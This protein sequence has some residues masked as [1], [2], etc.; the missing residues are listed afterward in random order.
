M[1]TLRLLALVP[2]MAISYAEEPAKNPFGDPVQPAKPDWRRSVGL[3]DIQELIGF[4]ALKYL[5]KEVAPFPEVF[6]P[7][8]LQTTG[9]G[10]PRIPFDSHDESLHV[11]E[12]Y[13]QQGNTLWRYGFD[14]TLSPPFYFLPNSTPNVV[15]RNRQLTQYRIWRVNEGVT[16]AQNAP[17]EHI[18]TELRPDDEA[19]Q[20]AAGHPATRPLSK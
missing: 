16:P 7:A 9:A 11:M 10:I 5:D 1:K 14:F 13:V 2:L 15:F 4:F 19:E 3:S 20:N 17:I 18:L 6:L 12:F 8:D